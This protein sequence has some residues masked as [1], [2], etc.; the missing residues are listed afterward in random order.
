MTRAK[1]AS[2]MVVAT[3]LAVGG[4][5]VYG[6]DSA[7]FRFVQV[8]VEQAGTR[9][10]AEAAVASP[11]RRPSLG[12]GYKDAK[13]GMSLGQVKALVGATPKEEYRT[14]LKFVDAPPDSDSEGSE[15]E[16]E[17]YEGALSRVTYAPPRKRSVFSVYDWKDREAAMGLLVGKYGTARTSTTREEFYTLDGL[18]DLP[19]TLHKWSDGETDITFAVTTYQEGGCCR[20]LG[21][22]FESVAL[23]ECEEAALAQKAAHDTE[24]RMR[25][26]SGD[27]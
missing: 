6:R 24:A 27:L 5:A 18:A 19:T 23:R 11:A 14:S 7:L 1:V 17:F 20:A 4:I 3:T 16:Y 10:R 25:G 15:T 9:V 22:T 26:M 8:E 12:G 2:L 21:V 13:W